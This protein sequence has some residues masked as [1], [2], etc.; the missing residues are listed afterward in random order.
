M[1]PLCS[2]RTFL[3]MSQ[4]L[5]FVVLLLSPVS[6]QPILWASSP[7]IAIQADPPFFSPNHLMVRLDTSLTWKNY[8]REAHSIVADDCQS[9]SQCSFDSGIIR[10]DHQFVLTR[11]AP[12][13][14]PYH[15]GLH[16]FMRGLLTIQTTPSPSP[17]SD[18]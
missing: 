11:L 17:S 10:P 1:T 13:A 18:I 15:C 8:T 4:L 3:Q 2:F 6:T 7:L 5:C 16:A 12:G 9:R 14:Y